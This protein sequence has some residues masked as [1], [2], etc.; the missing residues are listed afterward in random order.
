VTLAC[1]RVAASVVLCIKNPTKIEGPA[2]LAITEGTKVE[3]KSRQLKSRQPTRRCGRAT[4]EGATSAT[5]EGLRNAPKKLGSTSEA[6]SAL[7]VLRRVRGR[8]TR[9]R[10]A[11]PLTRAP[12]SKSRGY[13]SP[14][15]EGPPTRDDAEPEL[16]PE[17]ARR[18]RYEPGRG[19]G[20]PSASSRPYVRPPWCLPP[21]D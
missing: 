20:K 16:M 19:A 2:V 17:D 1:P 13:D 18:K 4:G 11:Q 3:L 8:S 14:A 7:D 15:A 21:G 5:G 10:R 9:W 12:S 6:T